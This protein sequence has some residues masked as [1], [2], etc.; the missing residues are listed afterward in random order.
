M[1]TFNEKL[2]RLEEIA[3]LL[4]KGD[5]ELENAVELYSEGVNL[6]KECNNTLKDAKLK[7][8]EYADK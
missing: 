3:T 8:T 6:I 4:E 7:V 5:C 1:A 2:E